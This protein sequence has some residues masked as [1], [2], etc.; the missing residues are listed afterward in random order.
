MV[1]SQHPWIFLII[2]EHS[3][4]S[5][6]VHSKLQKAITG[7]V[8]FMLIVNLTSASTTIFNIF[9][10]WVWSKFCFQVTVQLNHSTLQINYRSVS[11]L[12]DSYVGRSLLTDDSSVY[13][14]ITELSPQLLDVEL[15]CCSR[16]WVRKYIHMYQ[17]LYNRF[18][19]HLLFNV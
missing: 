3:C 5:I 11:A 12:G 1:S 6:A 7:V 17:Q 13:L 16:I 4:L 14:Q 19:I 10:R 15:L 18:I 2:S 8:N 9:P